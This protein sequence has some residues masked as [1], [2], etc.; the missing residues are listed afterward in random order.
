MRRPRRRAA[1]VRRP[2]A[3]RHAMRVG[4]GPPGSSGRARG[5]VRGH[6]GP[7]FLDRRVHAAARTAGGRIVSARRTALLLAPFLLGAAVLIGI[8]LAVAASR[9]G[10]TRPAVFAETPATAEAPE[11]AAAPTGPRE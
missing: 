6:H 10:P 3:P 11:E 9:P 5:R 7:P 1:E 8:A 2:S 4:A